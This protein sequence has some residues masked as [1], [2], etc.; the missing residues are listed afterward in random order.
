[1]EQLSCRETEVVTRPCY[2][3]LHILCC[4]SADG[5]AYI[6]NLPAADEAKLP[7]GAVDSDG[8][9]CP[10]VEMEGVPHGQSGVTIGQVVVEHLPLPPA[11]STSHGNGRY[12]FV[13]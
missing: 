8:S 12:N 9:V 1:M 2:F 4:I 6:A 7:A 3:F 5:L 11:P 13:M 10:V